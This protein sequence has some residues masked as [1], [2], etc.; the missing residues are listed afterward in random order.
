VF[1]AAQ[2]KSWPGTPQDLDRWERATRDDIST[3]RTHHRDR[4]APRHREKDRRLSSWH[5]RAQ[6]I[7]GADVGN[8]RWFMLSGGSG[9][10]LPCRSLLGLQLPFENAGQN[11][12]HFTAKDSM[13]VPHRALLQPLRPSRKPLS[14]HVLLSTLPRVL[15]AHSGT[16][17]LCSPVAELPANDNPLS[18][19]LPATGT[20]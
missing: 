8:P 7:G 2:H 5:P 20:D 4:K 14:I 12:Q 11:F 15:R 13:V 3:L 1:P 19:E 17:M 6:W 9:G 18:E 10:V 16:F